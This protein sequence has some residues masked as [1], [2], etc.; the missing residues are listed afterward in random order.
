MKI[1]ASIILAILLIATT[2]QAFDG[3]RKGFV[4][5]GGIGF[6]PVSHFSGSLP[7]TSQS[8]PALG[9]RLLVAIGLDERNMIGVSADGDHYSVAEARNLYITGLFIGVTWVHYL[10]TN[11]MSP[12]FSL[13]A[14]RFG[15]AV[16]IDRNAYPPYNDVI[17]YWNS[18]GSGMGI[19]IGAGILLQRYFQLGANVIVAR[20]SGM[21]ASP[22]PVEVSTNHLI[23]N[24]NATLILF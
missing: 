23:V 11:Q 19:D 15:H 21:S 5:G 14:G 20:T 17:S 2:I 1:R 24:I 18:D 8:Q 7:H 13:G 9:F 12:F 3:M 22:V 4:L 16:Y 10:K 6:V